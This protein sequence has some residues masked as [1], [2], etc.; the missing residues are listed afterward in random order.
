M[1]TRAPISTPLVVTAFGNC[2]PNIPRNWALWDDFL[3]W[4]AAGE[5]PVNAS[6][7]RA[8]ASNMSH[9]LHMQAAWR[10][11][12]GMLL[13]P[14]GCDLAF[15]NASLDFASMDA[16][17]AHLNGHQDVYG[18][19][20]RYATLAE[21]F[22]A[23]HARTVATSMQWPTRGPD[24]LTL[25]PL[26][27]PDFYPPIVNDTDVLGWWSGFFTSRPNLKRIARQAASLL[28]AAE[29]LRVL[30]PS[31]GEPSTALPALRSAVAVLQHHDAITGTC[32]PEVIAEYT[33]DARAASVAT[34]GELAVAFAQLVR[35]P[36]RGI[37]SARTRPFNAEAPLPHFQVGRAALS[38][39]VRTAAH[40]NATLAV[41]LHNPLGWTV[42]TS[43]EVVVAFHKRMP[44]SMVA[45]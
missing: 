12:T 1:C 24:P 2:P 8:F 20:V 4:G 44:P 30:S 18:V 39:A 26:G 5:A 14:W 22:S 43:I 41:L 35:E 40:S 13:W 16:L 19:K 3:Y 45:H 9:W 37:F 6:N 23:L 33:S 42:D 36:P 10:A 32:R 28:S 38:A 34:R 21:Y 11:P 15:H 31:R 7:V 17:V 27:T 29:A 25:V